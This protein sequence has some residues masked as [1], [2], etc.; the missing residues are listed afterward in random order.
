[1]SARANL[2]GGVGASVW[3]ALLNFL[4]TPFYLKYLGIEAYGVIGFYVALVALLSVLDMGLGPTVSR[5]IA[6][7]PAG[8]R[9]RNSRTL[10]FSVA[11]IYW[12]AALLF[13]LVG[14]AVAQFGGDWFLSETLSSESLKSSLVI[15]VAILSIRWPMILYQATLVGASRLASLGLVNAL[16]ATLSTACTL[17]VLVFVSQSLQAFFLTQMIFAAVHLFLVRGLAWQ[18]LGGIQGGSFDLARLR[19]VWKFAIGTGLI[20]LTSVAF[21]QLDKLIISKLSGLEDFGYYALAVAVASALYLIAS[22]LFNVIYPRMSAQ[23]GEGRLTDMESYYVLGSRLLACVVLPIGMSLAFY[24][25]DVVF[26]WTQNTEVAVHVGP[27]LSFL[28]LGSSLHAMMFFPYGVQLAM[29]NVRLP[30]FTNLG[31]MVL[32]V[33]ALVVAVLHL[34]ALGGAIMWFALQLVY[35]LVGSWLTHRYLLKTSYLHWLVWNTLLPFLSAVAFTYLSRQA[36]L[37]LIDSV[38]LRVLFAGL[39]GSGIIALLVLSSPRT[40][41]AVRFLLFGDRS[42]EYNSIPMKE[43]RRL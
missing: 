14:I 39:S 15:M 5:E 1:M 13:A 25:Q 41:D 4:A 27:L 3:V 38:M 10:V 21:T 26:L 34:G 16:T 8:G 40:R 17:L 28:A 37:Y 22:P 11:R 36:I 6:R 31:L 33:P 9:S 30:L 19:Q 2:L 7:D 23:Y 12:C 32:S 24:S 29:G 42:L 20:A 18:V 35:L 43:S